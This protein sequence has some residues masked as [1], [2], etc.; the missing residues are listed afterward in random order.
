VY[1]GGS[2]TRIGSAQYRYVA[3]LQENGQPDPN[4]LPSSGLDN[5]LNTLLAAPEGLYVAGGFQNVDGFAHPHL[6]RLNLQPPAISFSPSRFNPSN[7][8]VIHR[9]RIIPNIPFVL[10]ETQ[11]FLTWS[12]VQPAETR[13][14]DSVVVDLAPPA[15]TR[16][17]RVRQ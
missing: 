6:A 10:E 16:F 13:P 1:V 17:Y 9:F 3:R 2:F 14:E 15:G 12:E 5:Y 7:G 8:H 11:D 4:F